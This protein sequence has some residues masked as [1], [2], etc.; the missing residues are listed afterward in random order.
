MWKSLI[1]GHCSE[2][3]CAGNLWELQGRNDGQ[4]GEIILNSSACNSQG[5]DSI[6][7]FQRV[8][9]AHSCRGKRTIQRSAERKF[10]W[11]TEIHWRGRLGPSP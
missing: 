8:A 4:E 11:R 1:K 6:F 7:W 2:P 9:C 10:H 5:G 3:V